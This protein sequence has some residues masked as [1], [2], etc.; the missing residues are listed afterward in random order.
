M[1][2]SRNRQCRLVTDRV[3]FSGAQAAMRDPGGTD[4]P[5][6]SRRASGEGSAA[7]PPQTPPQRPLPYLSA[8]P[9]SSQARSVGSDRQAAKAAGVR[10]APRDEEM[11]AGRAAGQDRAGQAVEDLRNQAAKRDT[12]AYRLIPRPS[13]IPVQHPESSGTSSA[14]GG[15]PG[16]FLNPGSGAGARSE[17][18]QAALKANDA[19]VARQRAA[20]LELGFFPGLDALSGLRAHPLPPMSYATSMATSEAA[21]VAPSEAASDGDA[22]TWCVG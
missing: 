12:Q 15:R 2:C 11:G 18:T 4:N 17:L 19:E 5:P 6:G 13:A 16:E 10:F 7:A 3:S 8:P 22:S 21:S 9:P 14:K 1:L 20:G